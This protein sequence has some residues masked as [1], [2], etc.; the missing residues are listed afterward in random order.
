MTPVWECTID[1]LVTT[2]E[3]NSREHW[4]RKALRH[5]QQREAIRKA[6]KATGTA[7]PNIQNVPIILYICRVAPRKLD[8]SDNLPCSLKSLIDELTNCL[9]P[10][11]ADGR[12]DG[13]LKLKVAYAQ[14]KGKVRQYAVKIKLFTCDTAVV[15]LTCCEKIPDTEHYK[16]KHCLQ[17]FESPL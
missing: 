16:C 17:V 9:L 14:E 1:P 6:W 7:I 8:H 10:G 2:P 3:S 11:Y 5:S 15:D 13:K 12:A 4:H